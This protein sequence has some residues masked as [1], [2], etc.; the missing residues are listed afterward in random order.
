[1]NRLPPATLRRIRDYVDLHLDQNIELESLA[2][3]AELSVYHFAR[4]FKHSEGTTP[5]TFVLE[6]R[7]A[8]ARSY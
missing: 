7:L 4:I 8:R 5:H 6:R 2:A 3:T 1:L